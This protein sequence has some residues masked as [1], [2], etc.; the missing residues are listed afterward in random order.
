MDSEQSITTSNAITDTNLFS[1]ALDPITL[2]FKNK[3]LEEKYR[4]WAFK[5]F[6]GNYNIVYLFLAVTSLLFAI[7]NI[8]TELLVAGKFGNLEVDPPAFFFYSPPS[9]PL[10][11]LSHCTLD[12]RLA[13]FSGLYTESNNTFSIC[14][15]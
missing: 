11:E 7:G 5:S 9:K 2:S 8:Y 14:G 1:A 13:D 4:S 12:D 6:S 10:S 15:S 3:S